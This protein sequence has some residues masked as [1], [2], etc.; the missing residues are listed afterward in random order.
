MDS[1]VDFA[2]LLYPNWTMESLWVASCGHVHLKTAVFAKARECMRKPML[3]E[4]F[5]LQGFACGVNDCAENIA[6][7][8]FAAGREAASPLPNIDDILREIES[9]TGTNSGILYRTTRQNCVHI[10]TTKY[11]LTCY[12]SPSNMPWMCGNFLSCV[13]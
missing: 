9:E 7:E 6:K 5:L 3:E 11:V 10:S 1:G 12:N 4:E 2:V 13:R 8:V